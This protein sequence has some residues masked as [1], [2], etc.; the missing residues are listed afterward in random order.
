[1]TSRVASS[2]SAM[3]SVIRA[4]KSCCRARVVTPGAFQAALRSSGKADKIWGD[5]GPIGSLSR[6]QSGLAQLNTAQGRF[7]ALLQLKLQFDDALLFGLAFHPHALGFVC[8]FNRHRFNGPKKFLAN[9]R[10]DP[11]TT[12]RQPPNVNH[13]GK[14]SISFGHSQR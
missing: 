4:R 8:R 6:G 1:M 10:F 2:T 14:P 9:R 5:N 7:P 13:R 12:E 3:I 11:H